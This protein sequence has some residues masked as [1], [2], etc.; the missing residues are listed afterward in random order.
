M[1]TTP[2]QSSAGKIQRILIRHGAALKCRKESII[3]TI[4]LPELIDM[5]SCELKV[6]DGLD[7]LWRMV[8]RYK[9]TAPIVIRVADNKARCV[10][11]IRGARYQAAHW[12]LRDEPTACIRDNR[13]A[14][15]L[16]S[17]VEFPLTILA[18]CQRKYFEN[19]TTARRSSPNPFQII[20]TIDQTAQLLHMAREAPS[21]R[22]HHVQIGLQTIH[23]LQ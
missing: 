18:S 16:G 23:I 8:E 17:E 12:Q 1:L 2:K 4:V 11:A 5:A 7:R 14:P 15:P 10:R 20:L 6:Y 19:E 3:L 21:F 13:V 22:L 9:M